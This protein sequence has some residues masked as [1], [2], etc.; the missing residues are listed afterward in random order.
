MIREEPRTV[1]ITS[2]GREF[3]KRDE[4]ERAELVQSTAEILQS[5]GLGIHWR[6]TNPHDVAEA[7]VDAGYWIVKV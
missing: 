5:E 6:D 3:F 4:A 2:N 7:L 1:Y